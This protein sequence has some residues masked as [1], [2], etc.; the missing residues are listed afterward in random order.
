MIMLMI[1]KVKAG[2][3]F[4]KLSFTFN[5]TTNPAIIKSP[6]PAEDSNKISGS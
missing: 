3:D 4:I 1:A 6:S 2:D 5:L